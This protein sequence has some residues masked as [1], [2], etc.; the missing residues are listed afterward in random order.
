MK[1]YLMPALFA[2]VTMFV[3]SCAYLGF[4]G[5]SIKLHPDVHSGVSED[6]ECLD[7]H[8]PDK[9][10]Q[11]PPTPHPGFSGCIKCHND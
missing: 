10:I 8:H 4:H 1:G 3:C 5:H 11:G 2:C 7:C 9:E 6:H